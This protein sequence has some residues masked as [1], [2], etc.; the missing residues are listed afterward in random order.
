MYFG[1]Y[2]GTAE[3]TW[4]RSTAKKDIVTPMESCNEVWLGPA[5]LLIDY[6]RRPGVRHLLAMASFSS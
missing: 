6:T 3:S 5:Q 1:R 4:A 2:P